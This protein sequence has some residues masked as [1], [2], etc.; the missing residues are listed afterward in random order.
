MITSIHLTQYGSYD[1]M[2]VEEFIGFKLPYFFV[3]SII[4]QCPEAL[5]TEEAWTLWSMFTAIGDPSEKQHDKCEHRTLVKSA[6]QKN[7]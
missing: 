5:L 2:V 7:K 4:M 6:Y 3:I 1:G